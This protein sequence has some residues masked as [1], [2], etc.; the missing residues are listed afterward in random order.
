M[1]FQNPLH[2][3]A[4]HSSAGRLDMLIDHTADSKYFVE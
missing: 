1:H 3:N 2:L 4:K